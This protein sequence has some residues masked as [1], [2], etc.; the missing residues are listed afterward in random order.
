MGVQRREKRRA[1]TK[2]AMNPTRTSPCSR[3]WR[4]E[5]L[6]RVMETLDAIAVA[7]G[8]LRRLQAQHIELARKNRTLTAWQTQTLPG[9][10]ARSRGV[11]AAPSFHRCLHRD[12]RGRASRPE[13]PPGS[14]AKAR[15][16]AWPP[17]AAS[18]GTRSSRTM[19]AASWRRPGCRGSD[20]CAAKAGRPSPGR[21]VPRLSPFARTS[22]R[23]PGTRAWS[24]SSSS[25]S[26]VQS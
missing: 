25:G 9:A 26:P 24:R 1:P 18:R 13:P 23:W 4:R 20:G 12:A 11:N 5:L 10:E 16:C 7:Y 15:F 6:P 3:P 21:S 14:L 19:R 17:I 22:W 2:A 8:K